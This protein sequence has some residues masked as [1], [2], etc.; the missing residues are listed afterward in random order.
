MPRTP[1]ID[2]GQEVYHILNR[3]NARVQ[4]FDDDLDYQIFETMRGAG[5]PKNGG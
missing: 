3:A 1:R 5:R 4:I 2:I